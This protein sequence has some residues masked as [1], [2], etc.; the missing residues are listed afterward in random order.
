MGWC[1]FKE[2][3]QDL[4][5]TFNESKLPVYEIRSA[6]NE[7]VR[8]LFIRLQGG[9]PLQPQQVRDAW[10]GDVARF[11]VSLAGKKLQKP[12]DDI[13]LFETVLGLSQGEDDD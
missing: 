12:P 3:S 5:N 6:S 10:P 2:L 13:T 7:E 4:R 11:I 8:N 9:T 1:H